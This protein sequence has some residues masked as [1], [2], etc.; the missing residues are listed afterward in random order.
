MYNYIAIDP[1]LISTAMVI[2][3]DTNFK[4]FNFCREK[5]ALTKKG[6]LTK[7]YG[8]AEK[9]IEY[10]FIDLTEK[11]ESYPEIE[12]YKL[13][14]YHNNTDLIIDIILDNINPELETRVMIEGY[15][16]GSAVGDLIDLVTFSTLLRVKLYD[17]V[18]RNIHVISPKTLKLETCKMS[19]EPIIKTVGVR[20][21]KEVIEYKNPI[22]IKGGDFS[23]TDMLYSIIEGKDFTDEWAKHCR[24]IEKELMSTKKINKPYED[25]NDAYLMYSYLKK[26]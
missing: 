8:L 5:D 7:W 1:S 4:M 6:T 2:G 10:T 23:K 20:K 22:G 12:A 15:S 21:I 18:S 26:L 13:E 9:F 14:A 16:F 19:Y 25:V 24:A 11:G 3:N 17:K